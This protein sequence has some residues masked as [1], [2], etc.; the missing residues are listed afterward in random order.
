MTAAKTTKK[1][2]AVK[3]APAKRGRP[4]VYTED[5][6]RVVCLRI[7]NGESTRAI[8]RDEGM[9]SEGTIRAWAVDDLNGFNSQYTR[10]IQIRAMAWAEEIIE[11][12]DD[13]S[14]DLY[15][16]PE[17]GIEKTNHEVV[18]RSRLRTDSRKWMLSKVLPKIYG[19][20]QHVEHSG[21]VGLESLIAGD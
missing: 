9:P 14:D 6:A 2:P 20:R 10:A 3:K 4:S 17:S 21:K 18:A 16:D 8:A 7:A 11:I 15:V 5:L 19:D 1:K 12:S 13:S